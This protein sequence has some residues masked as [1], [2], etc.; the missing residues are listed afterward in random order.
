YAEETWRS[1]VALGDAIDRDLAS[2]RMG[3]T[4]GG[5]PTFVSVDDMD[6]AEWNTEAVG[7]NKRRIAGNLFRAMARRF[8]KGSLL[9]YG[10][11][12]WYPGEQLPRWALT[13]FWR[14]D[15]EPIWRDPRLIAHEEKPSGATPELAG[16]FAQVL[17]ERLQIDPGFALPA[18]EDTWY[19]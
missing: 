12:K 9:H 2:N 15:G 3:L 13:C 14:K 6:G 19:Y 1:I 8:G 18:F 11:G 16:R 4:M 5:E 10:Q 7:A 17:A